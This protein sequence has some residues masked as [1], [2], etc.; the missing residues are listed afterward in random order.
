MVRV[1]DLTS[2]VQLLKKLVLKA[3]G[4]LLVV[5][6]MRTKKNDHAPKSECT[7]FFPYSS[8]KGSFEK[9]QV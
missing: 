8:K 2:M 6:R 4:P 7:D 3:L 1:H 5:N 9:N